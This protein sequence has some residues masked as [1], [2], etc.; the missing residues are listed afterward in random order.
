MGEGLARHSSGT[1]A[2]WM[3]R[4][5]RRR[6]AK[7]KPAAG[8]AVDEVERSTKALDM[9][10][11]A[12]PEW[13]QARLLD[14]GKASGHTLAFLSRFCRRMTVAGLEPSRPGSALSLD[15]QPGGSGDPFDLVLFWDLLNYLQPDQ[16][17]QLAAFLRRYSRP[18][19]R[20][21]ALVYYSADMPAAP[22]RF[23]IE[24]RKTVFWSHT[25]SGRRPCPRYKEQELVRRLPG[26]EVERVFLLR[27]GIA[28]YVFRYGAEPVYL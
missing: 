27:Y 25:G 28:E 9:V 14:L 2:D 15:E 6:K 24:D 23:R 5:W 18:G 8:R 12:L 16:V 7:E 13:Q 20:L 10:L 11:S 3:T 17:A 21:L 1:L 19:T 22:A 4:D 26:F